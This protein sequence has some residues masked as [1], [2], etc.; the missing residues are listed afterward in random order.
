MNNFARV[1]FI[2][3]VRWFNIARFLQDFREMKA[4]AARL[5]R[6]FRERRVCM[7]LF[8]FALVYARVL[9]DER[10]IIAGFSCALYLYK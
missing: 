5:S 9:Q 8:E 4:R 1:G 2:S 6:D 7:V 3:G 10:E